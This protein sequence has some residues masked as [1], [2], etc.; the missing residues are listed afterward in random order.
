MKKLAV[1]LMA[2]ILVFSFAACGGG[3]GGT[4]E[5][6]FQ[7]ITME[8]PSAWKAEESTLS[9]D[10]VI[11][12]QKNKEGHDYRLLMQDTFGLLE[13]YGGDMEKAGAFFKEVT[14][15]DASYSD[16]SDPVAGKFGDYDMHTISCKLNMLNPDKEDLKATYPCKL[17][18]IYMG[19]HDVEIE[20][21]AQEGDFE[22][23]DQAFDA[24]SIE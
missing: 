3:S 17:I 7:G 16:V 22:A 6:S 1:A 10:Y 20:F 24:A 8:I 12:E 15:D 11:Y 23:F 18:R 21:S 2:V 5:V 13:T 9:D 19:D 4:Q 14:E